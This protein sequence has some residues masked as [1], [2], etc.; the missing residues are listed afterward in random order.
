MMEGILGHMRPCFRKTKQNR[1]KEQHIPSCTAVFNWIELLRFPQCKTQRLRSVA[2]RNQQLS[3][4]R[5]PGPDL[6]WMNG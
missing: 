1:Q 5:A 3:S 2:S 4:R 6:P